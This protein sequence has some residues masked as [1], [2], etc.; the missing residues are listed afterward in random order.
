MKKAHLCRALHL[1]SSPF[2]LLEAS[3]KLFSNSQ[4]WKL[5]L[6]RLNDFLLKGQYL[7]SGLWFRV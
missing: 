5:M 3:V 4:L 7:K 1:K 2:S 6:R